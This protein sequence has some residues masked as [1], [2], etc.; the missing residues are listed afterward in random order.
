MPAQKDSAARAV[1][2]RRERLTHIRQAA[3]AAQ[4]ADAMPA[5]QVAQ[6][7]ISKRISGSGG[8]SGELAGRITLMTAPALAGVTVTK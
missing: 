8:S 3:S 5:A 2:A 6:R 7:A 4:S 1:Q